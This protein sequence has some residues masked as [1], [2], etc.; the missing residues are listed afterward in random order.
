[1]T[2]VKSMFVD[3]IYRD[4]TIRV[5][6]RYQRTNNRTELDYLHATMKG[7]VVIYGTILASRFRHA[8]D[9]VTD[10]AQLKRGYYVNRYLAFCYDNR[11]IIGVCSYQVFGDPRD[12]SL[13]FIGGSDKAK[14]ILLQGITSDKFKRRFVFVANCDKLLMSL[15]ESTIPSVFVFGD[16]VAAINRTLSKSGDLTSYHVTNSKEDGVLYHQMNNDLNRIVVSFD[17]DSC[18]G[19]FITSVSD[20]DID[21]EPIWFVRNKDTV[22]GMYDIGVK[23]DIAYIGIYVRPEYRHHHLGIL[24]YRL[25]ADTIMALNKDVTTADKIVGV[26]HTVSAKNIPS[27]KLAKRVYGSPIATTF[28]ESLMQSIASIPQS[29]Q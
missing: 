9:I 22:V 25:I 12:I 4:G 24:I 26:V 7:L 29:K 19:G 2:N 21:K 10:M 1:M 17:N 18:G 28:I 14:A 8:V 23:G 15:M 11:D 27:V 16:T 5:V 3:E 6:S 13:D 20:Y